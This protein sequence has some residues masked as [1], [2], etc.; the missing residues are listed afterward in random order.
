MW[1]LQ[2]TAGVLGLTLFIAILC[3]RLR[4]G[5]AA[6]HGLWLL[7][8]LK[9]LIPPFIVWPWALS[10]WPEEMSTSAAVSGPPSEEDIAVSR[11]T[12]PPVSFRSVEEDDIAS[13]PTI[14]PPAPMFPAAVNWH[15]WI[16]AGAVVWLC[17]GV[18]VAFVQMRRLLRFR[19]A[20]KGVRQAPAALVA[21]VERLAALLGIRPP[22]VTLFPGLGS[23]LIWAGGRTCLLW[24]AGLEAELSPEGCRAVL[25]HEL[26]HLARRDHWVGRLLLLAGCVWWWHPLFYLVRRQL[27]R[28]AELSCD[29]RVVELLPDA[30]RSYAEAL[31]DVC[32]RQTW[33]ASL[34]PALGATNRRRDLERRLVMIMRAN[35]PGRL[36]LRMLGGIV[37]LGLI[38][39]PAWTLGQDKT[40]AKPGQAA[41][42]E[43]EK[44]LQELEKQLQ[45][46][47]KDLEEHRKRKPT[48]EALPLPKDKQFHDDITLARAEPVKA[49]EDKK[50]QDLE[51]KVK[52]LLKEV[53]TLRGKKPPMGTT[54]TKETI[55]SVIVDR[56]SDKKVD[57]LV[58]NLDADHAAAQEVTLSRTTYK[59]P[60]AKAE[61]LGKFLQEHV[62]AIV[63]ETKADGDSLTITTTPEVQQGIRQFIALIEGKAPS[64]AAKYRYWEKKDWAK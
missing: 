16:D 54:L 55:G 9:M 57:V 29:A 62:K 26:A 32:Q 31:L 61:A 51:A 15:R 60:A 22:P 45:A 4:L 6:R 50:L 58:A 39:L 23:P 18:I 38:S 25:F 20:L 46:V 40:T 19:Y 5:P 37:L 11:K 56:A 21:E 36:S 43:R 41:T 30:R 63:M 10:I 28:Q 44:H 7:V 14:P 1:L 24:P 33:T 52:A 35:V 2:H 48:A 17:G 27:Q 53:Q 49:A 59:L 64:N 34:A 8:L 13:S 42:A 47:L 3:R 12:E